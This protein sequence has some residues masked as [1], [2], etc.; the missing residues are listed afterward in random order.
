M[1]LLLLDIHPEASGWTRC[2]RATKRRSNFNDDP[3]VTEV[4]EGKTTSEADVS[5]QVWP[6]PGA[7]MATQSQRVN[8]VLGV[9]ACVRITVK[10]TELQ[11]GQL[12]ETRGVQRA[13]KMP[14][15]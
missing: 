10:F 1:R 13:T 11:H 6:P 7:K 4:K 15:V 3:C 5:A 2:E 9:H 14:C 12:T 8:V